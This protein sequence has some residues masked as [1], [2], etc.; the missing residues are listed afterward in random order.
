M[1]RDQIGAAA[2]GFSARDVKTEQSKWEVVEARIRE[3]EPQCKIDRAKRHAL[4]LE[5]ATQHRKRQRKLK[6]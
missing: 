4:D 6:L 1:A 2:P 3:V 5:E